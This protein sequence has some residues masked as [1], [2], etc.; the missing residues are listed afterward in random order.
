VQSICEGGDRGIPVAMNE[1]TITGL[2]FQNLA[3]QTAEQVDYRNEHL[4]ATKR[5]QV[6]NKFKR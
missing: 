2:A 5:V 4:E 1:N 6:G 3:R